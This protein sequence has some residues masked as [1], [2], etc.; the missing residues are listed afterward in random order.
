MRRHDDVVRWVYR[1]GR[2]NALARA[3]NGATTT[4]A[5]AGV[6]PRR[7]VTLEVRGRRTGR[8]ILSPMVVADYEGGRYL[9]AMLGQRAQWAA[10]SG[11]PA[12]TLFCATAD[13]R[14]FDSKR[15]RPV[16]AFR[17]S[18]ATSRWH[19]SETS[20]PGRPSRADSRLRA[21][22]N[23]DPRVPRRARCFRLARTQG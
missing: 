7:L 19:R 10:T 5:A 17:S 21:N 22:R 14:L 9:V 13:A 3:L 23:A 2:P 18:A 4:L 6:W 16:P 8:K 11:Q 15:S 12:A 20:H 1:R